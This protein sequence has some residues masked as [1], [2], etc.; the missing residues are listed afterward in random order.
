MGL[1]DIEQGGQLT[2]EV[3]RS[4]LKDYQATQPLVD[5]ISIL[6]PFDECGHV[7]SDISVLNLGQPV[8][9]FYD[10]DFFGLAQYQMSRAL[11]VVQH[12]PADTFLNTPTDDIIA[13][14]VQSYCINAPTLKR[15]EAYV[16]GPHEVEIER[17][18]Y[19]R[20]IRLRGTL[21]GL[22]V[23]FD[24]DVE[25]FRVNPNR[26]GGAP[27]GHL[28]RNNLILTMQGHDLK[29]EEVNQQFDA[30]LNEIEEYL[31]LQRS[32]AEEH[33]T[34]LPLRL[35]PEIESR[36][37]KLLDARKL[38][39]GL[40]FPIRARQDSPKTYVAPVVRKK[41]ASAP[42]STS[43][44]FE[45]EPV[46]EEANY[47][48][49]LGII[50]SMALVMERSPSAFQTMGEENLRQHF[51]VQLNGHFEGAASGETFNFSGKT[52]ILIRVKE[53]NI[54]IAECKFW[55]GEKTLLDT[56]TQ[57][58]RY[59]SW[60]DTKAAVLVFNRNQSFSGV[61]KVIQD[62]LPKHANIKRG[63]VVEAETRFRC[64]FG[65]PSDANREVVVTIL[66]FDVPKP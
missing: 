31:S 26:Y 30:R 18:D 23:P 10:Q 8:V 48:A 58:L 66:A 43:A 39:A 14:L 20:M 21:L 9:F 37:Q 62:A 38:V 15:D 65:N 16:D 5:S 3:T 2:E 44:P 52:D 12:M 59:L 40:A 45:P 7:A 27:R 29:S 36:K 54:F 28:H 46:L 17:L 64:V 49:I 42:V 56:I 41:V 19:A 35:R 51:L 34:A 13:E 22:I 32:L 61:V 11:S 6:I 47:Q 53:R 55:A 63:P 50:Q 1:S 25:M 60:R 24:G 4:R 33:R 57:L